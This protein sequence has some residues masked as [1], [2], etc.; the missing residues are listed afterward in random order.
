MIGGCCCCSSLHAASRAASLCAVPKVSQAGRISLARLMPHPP[1]QGFLTAALQNHA[2]INSIPID[3]LAFRFLILKA[4]DETE[5]EGD[6]PDGILVKGLYLEGGA[7]DLTT[8]R[9]TGN[10]GLICSGSRSLG[11]EG[12]RHRLAA[13]HDGI[14]PPQASQRAPPPA[15]PPI[16]LFLLLP[17]VLVF[18][19]PLL[20]PLPTLKH[21]PSVG[22]PVPCIFDGKYFLSPANSA[23]CGGV[24]HT[25]RWQL[26]PLSCRAETMPFCMYFS[27]QAG[28]W[29][30]GKERCTAGCR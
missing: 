22:A 20:S 14:H 3:Q 4:M 25:S 29:S 9:L 11:L 23:A 1:L 16:P 13:A 30:P 7:W 21:V 27:S 19:L 26:I 5:V 28:L 6:V 12:L 2:R 10:L 15:T 17:L 24:V 8:G 18:P